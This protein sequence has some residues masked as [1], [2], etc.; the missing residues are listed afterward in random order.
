M[1]TRR[2]SQTVVAANSTS[3]SEERKKGC[4]YNEDNGSSAH[5]CTENKSIHIYRDIDGVERKDGYSD[6]NPE[7]G[8]GNYDSKVNI[9]NHDYIAFESDYKHKD[10]EKFRHR[11]SNNAF[12][13][14]DFEREC[15]YID[16]E[17][18]SQSNISESEHGYR[19]PSLESECLLDKKKLE[20]IN[21]DKQIFNNNKENSKDRLPEI[22]PIF[23]VVAE[24]DRR[25]PN[26]K[27]ECRI[28]QK[29]ASYNLPKESIQ[30]QFLE[31]KCCRVDINESEARFMENKSKYTFPEENGHIF[32]ETELLFIGHENKTNIIPGEEQHMSKAAVEN[33]YQVHEITEYKAT[34]YKTVYEAPDGGWGWVIVVSSCYISSIYIGL[35]L[36]FG[37]LFSDELIRMG[38]SATNV[39]WI[40]NLHSFMWHLTSTFAG[41]LCQQFSWRSV[42][43]TGSLITSVAFIFMS[44]ASSP[45]HIF[46]LF[47]IVIGL[48]GGASANICFFVVA[49]YFT[50]HRGTAT[51]IIMAGIAAGQIF[52]PLLLRMLQDKYGFMGAT[53]IFSAIVSNCCVAALTFHPVTNHVKKKRVLM[54]Q[55]SQGKQSFPNHQYDTKEAGTVTESNARTVNILKATLKN[56]LE[57]RRLE[58]TLMTLGFSLLL[59][60]YVNFIAQLPFAMYF[61]GHSLDEA[62]W[63]VSLS[64]I[65]NTLT[66]ILVSCVSDRKW[67]SRK[68]CYITG[69]IIAGFFTLGTVYFLERV[70]GIM[71]C[72]ILWGI[73]IGAN[74][75]VY[76]ALLIDI[77]GLPLYVPCLTATGLLMALTSIVSGPILG[78]IS[79]YSSYGS[80]M[81][82]C[83]IMQFSS[84]LLWVFMSSPH[85]SDPASA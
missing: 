42:S 83:A 76:H 15:Q 75:S 17:V 65:G 33:G 10:S 44:F 30:D 68:I 5:H 70:D 41:P 38:V 2:Y 67:F 6:N 64:A 13:F 39:S 54:M 73:G 62:S 11:D 16:S 66:R 57:M 46:L 69:S 1:A 80:S 85:R 55:E 22:Q 60:G 48:S 35:V 8:S 32:A 4:G 72:M 81:V 14:K 34:T 50:S 29:V 27:K 59:V 36:S 47:S 43:F 25:V 23:K 31:E 37:M 24:I 3:C 56:V 12:N 77:C 40:L 53:L 20:Y 52:V 45:I 18:G 49:E 74:L 9:K 7:N 19:D 78:T 26:E 63:C 21:N 84:A 79:D 58:V 82:A 28:D 61:K 51:A 71:V